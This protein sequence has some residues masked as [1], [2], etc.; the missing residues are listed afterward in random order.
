LFYEYNNFQLLLEMLEISVVSTY[1]FIYFRLWIKA[2]DLETEPKAKKRVF[3]KA[4]E[5]VPNSVRL[6]KLAVELEEPEDARILLARAVECCPTS[7]ELWLALA[8]LETYENARKVLNKAREHIPTG[9]FTSFLYN[10]CQVFCEC[11]L[12]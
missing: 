11:V 1:N 7:T 10:F 8:K 5:Q 3:R 2:A 12:V 6:W 4:L 9:Y